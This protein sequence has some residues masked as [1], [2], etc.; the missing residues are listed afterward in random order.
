MTLNKM[1]LPQLRDLA[2]T[3]TILKN[4]GEQMQEAGLV[5]EFDLTPGQVVR[6]TTAFVMPAV[7][8]PI[9]TG[10]VERRA[11]AD[12]SLADALI[13]AFTPST[14][15]APSSPA[16][17]PVEPPPADEGQAG[18]VPIA[19][20][21]SPAHAAE[22]RDAPL[23]GSASALAASSLGMAS[24]WT[25]EEDARLV[26]LVVEGVK[27][28][29]TRRQAI[30]AAA[31][32]IGRP[33]GGAE[34]R[35][36]HKLAARLHVAL[37]PDLAAEPTPRMSP[38][39]PARQDAEQAE[40]A[41]AAVE[42]IPAAVQTH[43]DPLLAHLRGVTDKGGWSLQRDI[44]LLEFAI[45][46]WPASDIALE[47]RMQVA[48][49]KPRLDTLTG[50]HE[51]EATGKKVRRWTREEVLAGLQALVSERVAA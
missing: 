36:K 47:I 39:E 37:M 44:D 24:A 22:V 31:R 45:L 9:P 25:A 40:V 33:E 18:G 49:I 2:L 17:A 16:P 15:A 7:A 12:Q 8:A 21:T 20:V 38:A 35:C 50:L 42:S 32:E 11:L 27:S 41:A 34:F 29:M 26:A 28:G 51:D 10:F 23:P 46:G 14:V 3:L 19:A 43:G 6:I 48:A 30:L 13:D 4:A 5:P 1:T